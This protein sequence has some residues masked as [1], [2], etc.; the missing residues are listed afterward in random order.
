MASLNKTNFTLGV[1]DECSLCRRQTVNSSAF[2]AEQLFPCLVY[3]I[4]TGVIVQQ[5]HKLLQWLHSLVNG[6]YVW[7]GTH[8]AK[9][10][11]DVSIGGP[12]VPCS[13]LAPVAKTGHRVTSSECMDH[14][15]GHTSDR[16]KS[17]GDLMSSDE[18]EALPSSKG[19]PQFRDVEAIGWCYDHDY[20]VCINCA[21]WHFAVP[22]VRHPVGAG[23]YECQP[24]HACMAPELTRPG[25]ELKNANALCGD[26]MFVGVNVCHV[27]SQE[28]EQL[29]LVIV[30]AEKLLPVSRNCTWWLDS[31]PNS[32]SSLV[33][34]V[35][36]GSVKAISSVCQ[37]IYL[38]WFQ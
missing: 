38:A 35:N 13:L 30:D 15:Q 33:S 36:S 32:L 11:C 19:N 9:C 16:T 18:P 3:T 28:G 1:L 37:A 4:C 14:R 29:R 34:S 22:V 12:G 7:H 17:F 25:I 26:E 10:W 6:S 20:H 23:G 5:D 24:P 31:S 2:L 21:Y 27:R 8:G